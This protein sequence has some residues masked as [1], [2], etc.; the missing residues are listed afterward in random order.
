MKYAIDRYGIGAE[1]EVDADDFENQCPK[2][3]SK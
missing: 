2:K 1:I 3:K